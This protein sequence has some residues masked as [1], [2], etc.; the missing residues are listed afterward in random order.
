MPQ[1]LALAILLLSTLL[2]GCASSGNPA[3]ANQELGVKSTSKEKPLSL[4]L[5]QNAASYDQV[6]FRAAGAKSQSCVPGGSA[7]N[8]LNPLGTTPCTQPGSSSPPQ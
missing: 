7:V 4:L 1:L 8:P 5:F 2:Y 6:T 3:V